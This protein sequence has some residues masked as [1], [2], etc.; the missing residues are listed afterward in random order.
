[1]ATLE[2]VE[3]AS[4]K[5]KK[6][7]KKRVGLTA[8]EEHKIRARLRRYFPSEPWIDA[9]FICIDDIDPYGVPIAYRNHNDKAFPLPGSGTKMIRCP[10]CERLMP[11]NH[12]EDFQP[13]EMI[14]GE[15]Q[16]LKSTQRLCADHK[17]EY[18]QDAWGESPSA[19]AI[20]EL[21]H[22]NLRVETTKTKPEGKAALRQE[23]KIYKQTGVIAE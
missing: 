22:R 16:C 18:L 4:R 8:N 10:Y 15:R 17:S 6:P 5:Q 12:F 23:I 19:K 7:K 14:M 9:T 20:R 21:Q 3:R 13:G 2:A 11:P 1:M